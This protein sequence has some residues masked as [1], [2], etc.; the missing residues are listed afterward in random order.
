MMMMMMTPVLFAA[1]HTVFQQ[2]IVHNDQH[3]LIIFHFIGNFEDILLHVPDS[4]HAYEVENTRS[5]SS[6]GKF[7]NTTLSVLLDSIISPHDMFMSPNPQGKPQL[8]SFQHK[9]ACRGQ[10]NML[11]YLAQQCQLTA[12]L[13]YCM[14]LPAD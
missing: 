12:A 2:S 11:V 6:V 5:F 7:R 8:A 3:H 9:L 1:P 10:C 4:T 13:Q 14:K